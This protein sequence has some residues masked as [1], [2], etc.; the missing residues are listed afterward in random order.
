MVSA[1]LVF[2]LARPYLSRTNNSVTQ[3]V[4]KKSIV[5]HGTVE[6][7]GL[8]PPDIRMSQESLCD[9]VIE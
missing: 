8:M 1:C 9:S 4:I 5:A 6:V 7:K 2:P 3:C